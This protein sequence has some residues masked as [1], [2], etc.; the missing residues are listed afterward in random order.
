M[1]GLLSTGPTPSS[2][3]INKYNLLNVL[4]SMFSSVTIYLRRCMFRGVKVKCSFVQLLYVLV[5]SYDNIYSH[6]S[7]T[8]VVQFGKCNC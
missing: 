1:E 2:S 3:L 5:C 8:V 7:V 4:L 6:G